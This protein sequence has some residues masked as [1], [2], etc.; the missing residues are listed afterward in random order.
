MKHKVVIN[1]RYGGFKLSGN[2]LKFLIDNGLTE[3]EISVYNVDLPRHHPLLVQAV[4]MFHNDP[5]TD[6]IVVEIDSCLYYIDE[7][8]GLES[9]MTPTNVDWEVIESEECQK[10]YPEY[11]I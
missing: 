5:D 8:D 2:M 10:K 3:D 7:Y 6:L 1:S 4:E 11:F 9:V